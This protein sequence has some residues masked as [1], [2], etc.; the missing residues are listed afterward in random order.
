MATLIDGYNLLYAAGILRHNVGPGTL[1]RARLALL[2]F[3]AASLDDAQRNSTTVVFD[4]HAAPPGLPREETHRG[5]RVRYAVGYPDADSLLGE[6]IRA[7]PAPRRLVVVSSDHQIQ[8]AAKHRRAT[9]VDSDRWYADLC[10]QRGRKHPGKPPSD[11]K[12]VPPLTEEEIAHWLETFGDIS[13]PAIPVDDSPSA[14]AQSE[15]PVEATD[16]PDDAD[17][18]LINPFPPGYAEDLLREDETPD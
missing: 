13:V 6:L 14:P 16:K 2:D 18:D 17:P 11:L 15:P 4:A 12:P 3:L 5:L 8:R 9:A 1:E 10:R 7:D